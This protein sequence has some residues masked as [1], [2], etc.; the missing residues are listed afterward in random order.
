MPSPVARLNPV[1]CL[2]LPPR[3][4]CRFSPRLC[5]GCNR[6]RTPK[7]GCARGCAPAKAALL[8]SREK[9]HG[10][11]GKKRFLLFRKRGKVQ[12]FGYSFQNFRARLAVRVLFLRETGLPFGRIRSE[13]AEIF[14]VNAAVIG[15]S[16]AIA[17]TAG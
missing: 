3:A 14:V 16:G 15:A 17:V 7:D 1:L 2:R 13:C 9:S 10:I 4:D 11:T 5:R 8:L 12:N 6:A